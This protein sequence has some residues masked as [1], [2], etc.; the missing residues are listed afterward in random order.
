[1][2]NIKLLIF[3]EEDLTKTLAESFCA[4][5]SFGCTIER[6]NEFS[7]PL[8]EDVQEDKIIVVNVNKLN[9]VL[10][11]SISELS[12]DKRNNFIVISNDRST[13]LHVQ[14]L[15]A[16]AKDFLLKPLVKHDF[17]YTI[18]KIYKEN[19][20][21]QDKGNFSKVY[22]A[23][24]KESGQGKTVFLINLAKELAD[25]SGEKVLLIDFNNSINDVSFLLNLDISHNTNYYF[26][27]LN[28][29]NAENLISHLPNYKNSSLYVMANGFNRNENDKIDVLQ[30]DKSLA[31]LKQKFK[32]IF[33]D[34]DFTDEKNN[35]N[36]IR[37]SD[38]VFYL[39]PPSPADAMKVQSD[40]EIFY[41]HKE[42]RLII[43]TFGNKEEPKV[44][45]IK[46]T[47]GREV[48]ARIPKNFM[49]VGVS[50]NTRKTL[51]EI[52]PELDI[53]KAYSKIAKSIINRD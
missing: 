35:E 1:M 53:V 50:V 19:I 5:L 31:L 52:S 40:L 13:D 8:V 16:G 25:M 30:F 14:A 32:Y 42:I 33:I 37:V 17:I 20:L 44:E 43:N 7:A 48:F 23:S 22:T 6:Y 34:R 45:K 2:N 36:V 10:L 39:M 27:K 41:K 9:S 46:E 15:R 21:K 24:S 11:K 29:Q 28:E 12:T 18:Q 3:D 38:I 26:N 4:D 49:A 51:K 47:L